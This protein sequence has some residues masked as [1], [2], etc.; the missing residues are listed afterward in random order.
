MSLSPK[1]DALL[2]EITRYDH[3]SRIISFDQM[4]ICPDL[5]RPYE[6]EIAALMR[7]K[8][9][10]KMQNKAFIDAVLA[11]HDLRG[12]LD[13]WESALENRLYRLYLHT[14]NRSITETA[15]EEEL[16][17]RAFT[18]WMKAREEDDFRIFAPAL[19]AL[20]ASEKAR[21]AA[22][23][24]ETAAEE[25]MSD[26][27]RMLDENEP[28][29]TEETLDALFKRCLEHLPELL[30]AVTE[31]DKQPRVDFLSR[32]VTDEQQ[33]ALTR[34]LLDLLGFDTKRGAYGL[35]QHPFTD[36]L[37]P[38]DVRVTTH[39]EPN[40]FLSNM[41]S[42]LHEC[43]HGLFEQLQPRDNHKYHIADNKTM[44][45]HESV[46]RFYENVIGRSREFIHLIY[47][48]LCEIFPQVFFDVG[49]EDLYEAV[50]AVTP[51]LIRMDADEL[52]Y[53]LHIIIR[54]EL[55]KQ[56][57]DG[58]LSVDDL[59]AAWNKA[60]EEMLGVAPASDLTGMLQDSHWASSFGYFPT[61]ALGN[62]YGAMYLHAIRADFDFDTAVETGDFARI[63]AW[64]AEHVFK[65]ADRLRADEWIRAICGR[66]LTADDFLAYLDEKYSLIYRLGDR[67]EARKE[68]ESYRRHMI[69][70]RRL[71]ALQLDN[72]T[73]TDAYRSALADN[74][75]KIG[76]LA[77][78]NRQVMDNVI[79]PILNSKDRLKGS[80]VR[81]LYSFN[82]RLMD[83]WTHENIDLPVMSLLSARMMDDAY[84]SH[85]DAYIIR[86]LDQEIIA[87][88]AMC[89]ETRRI[90]SKPE[91]VA[92]VRKR[93]LRAMEKMMVYLE[94]DRFPSLDEESKQL[95][96]INSRYGDGLFVTLM[97]LTEEE[98]QA[99][100]AQ[101]KRS[102]D[103]ASDPFY[104]K[105]APNYDWDYHL[106]RAYQY[107]ANYDEFNNAGN[108]NA[109]ELKEIC[110]YGDLLEQMWFDKRD[111]FEEI[112]NYA[113][114]HA[115]VLR[116]HMHAGKISKE[117]YRDE[118]LT[119]YRN[120]AADNFD[121]D[122]I[123]NNLELP[124]EYIATLDPRTV[125][126]EQL[127]E[128][129][130]MYREILSYVLRMPKTGVFYEL[131]DYYAPM[132]FQ[133]I[134]L[135]GSISFEEMVLRSLAAFHP[136]TYIHSIMV[137]QISRCLTSHLIK[138][139]PELFVGILGCESIEDVEASIYK[140]EEFIFHA[141]LCH[142]FGKLIIID[143]IFMYGRALFTT[144][145]DIIRQHPELGAILLEKHASTRE[146]ADIARGHH[147]WYNGK[148]GY[149][150]E[151]SLND[152]PYK[153]IILIVACADCMD[154]ATDSVGRSYRG[155]IS[156]EAYLDEVRSGAG[157]RYA[158]FLPELLEREEVLED[159][160]YL[161]TNGRQ[162][163]YKK[164]WLL[165]R[166]VQDS[167]TE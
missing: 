144:E 112:D 40:S 37:N 82:E 9:F 79:M 31:S 167:F 107:A 29:L 151:F 68:F 120:R 97:P 143:T 83:A 130:T 62:F 21:V 108:Y 14:K 134:E 22:F 140:I 10:E 36:L 30:K 35:T 106:Y 77:R 55:E 49:E 125:T 19:S 5:G 3:A 117:T 141:A 89:I 99:R 113:Y 104:L 124:G 11:L 116:N 12:T 147:L 139:S 39:Y 84:A 4:T 20:I 24:T 136:P 157:T 129:D 86:Q 65:R 150:A 34:Y 80:T 53:T 75:R 44:G 52:T 163:A 48:K 38:D 28:G 146:Y 58:S 64:M 88:N 70:I 92:G 33:D 118:L 43:G 6:G 165:L 32:P 145:F 119:L 115:H 95:V 156:L 109:D 23:E 123:T 15:Q 158:P 78:E 122:S 138:T 93:G 94:K 41:Y 148:S 135:P 98:R 121:V 17:S 72:I 57:I 161:L 56:L 127:Q 160:K 110:R 162:R 45:M 101:L 131:M 87:C 81:Q 54:Y 100:F 149:P 73:G 60:Y 126:E 42:V 164:A 71:S 66:E 76:D 111:R 103:L 25:A 154:A 8:A 61:Y 51:S 47:P 105:E 13:E 159:L 67:H 46:S 2:T 166:G 1:L 102:I 132:I 128:A 85:D 137:A 50:N 59:P 69:R 153:T 63:N 91:L 142:D 90:L 7:T 114:N 96:L 74:F 26:Y 18:D 133:F 152:S 27:A 16:K 155:G